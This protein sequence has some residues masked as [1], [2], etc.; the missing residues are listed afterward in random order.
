[1]AEFLK[2]EE[3]KKSMPD[4]AKLSDQELRD[5]EREVSELDELSYYPPNYL[6]ADG[7]LREQVN[8]ASD[9]QKSEAEAKLQR[10]RDLLKKYPWYTYRDSAENIR[11]NARFADG[12]SAAFG[13]GGT[14]NPEAEAD[15]K[16]REAM[17]KKYSSDLIRE[18]MMRRKSR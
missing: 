11:A 18:E 4:L 9:D 7:Y 17:S 14:A 15:Y 12:F 16:V 6:G 13:S 10:Y 1:M 8:K 2:P 3:R 5:L